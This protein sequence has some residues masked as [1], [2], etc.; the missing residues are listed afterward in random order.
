MSHYMVEFKYG[1]DNI[2]GLVQK[3]ENRT[4]LIRQSLESFNGKLHSFFYAYGEYDGVLIAEF[5]D[6]ESCTAFLLMVTS[7]GGVAGFKT[8]VLIDPEEAT[9]SMRR[10]GETKTN[11][12]PAA[13]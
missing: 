8:T 1:I 11:Y 5:P 3:P 12:R 13:T 6:S 4:T 7:K 10:A 9:R 2:K